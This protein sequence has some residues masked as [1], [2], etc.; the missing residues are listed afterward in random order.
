MEFWCG[1]VQHGCGFVMMP[2]GGWGTGLR[3]GWAELGAPIPLSLLGHPNPWHGAEC[4]CQPSATGAVPTTRGWGPWGIPPTRGSPDLLPSPSPWQGPE[5]REPTQPWLGCHRGQLQLPRTGA[6]QCLALLPPDSA[7]QQ[8][9]APRYPWHQRGAS[10]VQGAVDVG[11]GSPREGAK[12]RQGAGM[13]FGT[14]SAAGCCWCI[15]V[16]APGTR[17]CPQLLV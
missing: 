3:A 2:R 16:F 6:S 17:P 8:P 11:V 15:R 9:G 1:V 5:G 4:G 14:R 7:H 12:P 13:L 10:R